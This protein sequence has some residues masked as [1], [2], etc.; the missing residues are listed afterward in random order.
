MK[1]RVGHGY[2]VHKLVEDRKLIIGGVE[3]PHYK[4]LLGHSD[5]DVLAHAICDALLGAAALGDIGKHFPDN[6]D[7]YKDVDSL[8][9]LEKVCELIRNKGY[10]ISNVDSTILA[11]APKLRPYIDEMRSKLAKAMKLDIDE[12]S[13]KATT[14]EKL[15]FTGREEGIAAHAVVLLMKI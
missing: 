10:E 3:I 11:Q 1:F 7:R 4:G 2:D 9:L 5:A 13:V 15:G 8:V 12:L 14:E 6:D